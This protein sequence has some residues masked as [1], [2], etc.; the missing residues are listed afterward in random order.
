MQSVLYAITTHQSV[1]PS[2]C[3]VTWADVKNG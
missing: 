1:Y 2:V 3:S